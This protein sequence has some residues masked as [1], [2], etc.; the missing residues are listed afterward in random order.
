MN[1]EEIFP[2]N[3]KDFINKITSKIKDIPTF[4]NIIKLIDITRI[5]EKKKIIIKY[6][7][8]NAN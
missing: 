6:L 7:K 2:E 4:G 8:I 1:F 3:K 5:Q